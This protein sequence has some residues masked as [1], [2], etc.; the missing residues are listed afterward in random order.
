MEA[1]TKHHTVHLIVLC[2]LQEPKVCYVEG[3]SHHIT[4]LLHMRLSG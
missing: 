3:Y 4:L 2:H 1:D